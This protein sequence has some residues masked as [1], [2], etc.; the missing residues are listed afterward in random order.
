[1]PSKFA[2][3]NQAAVRRMIKESVDAAIAAK[4]ARQTNAGNNASGSGQASGQV[5]AP[6]VRECTFAGF[7]KWSGSRFDTAYPRSWIRRVGDFLEHGYA[8]SSLMDTA[9]WSLE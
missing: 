5:I 7:M 3:L 1:M 6:V 2:P 8:V 4:R 9:Y